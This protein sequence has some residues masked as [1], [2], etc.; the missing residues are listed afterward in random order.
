MCFKLTKRI[1][2]NFNITFYIQIYEGFNI[3]F[4]KK[5]ELYNLELNLM[6]ENFFTILSSVRLK[7]NNSENTFPHFCLKLCMN[8][9]LS[10]SALFVRT[11]VMYCS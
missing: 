7:R 6:S 4:G 3:N 2:A 8:S 10:D 5:R 11:Y 9:H 1:N